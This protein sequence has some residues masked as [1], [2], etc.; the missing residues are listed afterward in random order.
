MPGTA[1][2]GRY[3]HLA[4]FFLES[5]IFRKKK[6]AGKIKPLFMINKVFFLRKSRGL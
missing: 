2:E 5:K 6:L 1:H 3:T 4:E